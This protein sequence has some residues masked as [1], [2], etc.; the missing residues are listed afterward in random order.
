MSMTDQYPRGNANW[1]SRPKIDTEVAFSLANQTL[2]EKE[3]FLILIS[4]EYFKK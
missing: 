3:Q 1:T 4:R 2:Q